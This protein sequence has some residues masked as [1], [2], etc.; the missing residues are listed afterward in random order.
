MRAAEGAAGRRSAARALFAKR[1]LEV[2]FGAG[3]A[4]H[5]G[6]GAD[7]LERLDVNGPRRHLPLINNR[8]AGFRSSAWA[9]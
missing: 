3:V 6:P 9:L 1:R 5:L 4:A 2:L 8:R 7:E